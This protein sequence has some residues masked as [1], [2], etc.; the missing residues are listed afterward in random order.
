M[1]VAIIF[2]IY[3]ALVAIAGGAVA[4]SAAILGTALGGSSWAFLAVGVG[5]LA[6]ASIISPEGF[7]EAMDRVGKGGAAVGGAIGDVFGG[8]VN[9]LVTGIGLP[10]LALAVG[11]FLIL[12]RNKSDST[13]RE[14]RGSDVREKPVDGS[15][16]REKEGLKS[17]KLAPAPSYY[18]PAYYSP[19]PTFTSRNYA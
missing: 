5:L 7:E 6:I 14:R 3:A 13:S 9:G 1:I 8:V 10:T 18:G 11:A 17:E 16:L 15:D 2:L 19:Q 12:R 4:G